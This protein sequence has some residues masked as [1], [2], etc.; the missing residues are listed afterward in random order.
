ML[1]S[2]CLVEVLHCFIELHVPVAFITLVI[3]FMQFITRVNSHESRHTASRSEPGTTNDTYCALRKFS[4]CEGDDESSNY[5]GAMSRGHC[6]LLSWQQDLVKA[7]VM[8]SASLSDFARL[9]VR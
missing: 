4:H 8:L 5:S 3:T 6:S 9:G 2:I 1:L 7:G